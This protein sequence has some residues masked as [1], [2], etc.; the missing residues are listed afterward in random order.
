MLKSYGGGASSLVSRKQGYPS[1][2]QEPRAFFSCPNLLIRT[3]HSHAFYS[4]G[5]A[6]YSEFKRLHDT[7]RERLGSTVT[8]MPFPQKAR[9]SR[10]Q[11]AKVAVRRKKELSFYFTHLMSIVEVRTSEAIRMFMKQSL[12]DIQMEVYLPESSRSKMMTRVRSVSQL[13]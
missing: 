9:F 4:G 1:V 5:G 8:L 13:E 2:L 12:L 3:T 11:V 6:R 7:I 10:S